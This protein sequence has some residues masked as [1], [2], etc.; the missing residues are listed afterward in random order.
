MMK[1]YEICE[2]S[3]QSIRSNHIYIEIGI[4][5]A[6]H[7]RSTMESILFSREI[8]YKSLNG[9]NL[10]YGVTG[11]CLHGRYNEFRVGS[12][13]SYVMCPQSTSEIKLEAAVHY[14]PFICA[15]I[16]STS[17]RLHTNYKFFAYYT[18]HRDHPTHCQKHLSNS[19][20][21]CSLTICL[22]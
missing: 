13:P 1:S 16:Y 4:D 9:S 10:G 3:A 11:I 15:V 18:Q 12:Q 21:I 5:Y 14:L 8:E 2:M 20:L 19:I 17:L 22:L 6:L 7:R